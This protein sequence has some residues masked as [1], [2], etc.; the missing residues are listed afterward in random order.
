[1]PSAHLVCARATSSP[2]KPASKSRFRSAPAKSLGWTGRPAWRLISQNKPLPRPRCRTPSLS[3]P[4]GF[5][6]QWLVWCLRNNYTFVALKL[7]WGEARRRECIP[8]DTRPTEQRS[9]RPISAQPGGRHVFWAEALLLAPH[10]STL[11][12]AHRS[13]LAS[14]QNPL[15]R[16]YSYFGD[17]TLVL[18]PPNATLR[19]ACLFRWAHLDTTTIRLAEVFSLSSPKG[20]EGG[21]EEA[22][23][24]LNA[25]HPTRSS[26]GEGE[27][28]FSNGECI[29]MRCAS[30]SLAALRVK[31]PPRLNMHDHTKT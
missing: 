1:M 10:R 30:E 16:M 29:K 19:A 21:G 14:A 27:G 28:D 5:C 15:P 23:I 2:A 26:R 31:V 17:T 6:P 8:S 12:Y 11:G 7:A 20:G 13:R 4:S 9:P 18:C 3:W 25:P 22:T 24:L